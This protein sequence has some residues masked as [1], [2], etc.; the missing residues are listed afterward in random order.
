MQGYGGIRRDVYRLDWDA[1]G[2]KAWG[3]GLISEVSTV[4]FFLCGVVGLGLGGGWGSE[5][6]GLE[7]SGFGV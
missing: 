4:V 1:W 7:W 3:L 2:L 6:C 5:V